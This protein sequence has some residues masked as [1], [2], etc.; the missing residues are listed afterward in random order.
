MK[1][2]NYLTL[3]SA[4]ALV[5]ATAGLSPA[6]IGQTNTETADA[7]LL[8]PTVDFAAIR[9]NQLR[10]GMTVAEVTSIMGDATKTVDYVNHAGVPMQTLEFS[11]GPIRSTITVA[12]GK[13]SGLALDVFKVKRDDLPAFTRP[14]WPGLHSGAV[15]GLLGNPRETRHHTYFGIK[16]DQL[17]FRRPGE[18]EISTFFVENHLVA[19]GLGQGVPSD[20][21]RVVL[22]SPS[23]TAAEDSDE[24]SIGI[25]NTASSIKALYGAARLD[26]EYRLNGQPAEHAIY[27]MQPGGSFVDVTFVDGVVTEFTD[28]GR[29]PD[30]PIFQGR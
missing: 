19:K 26:V 11:T 18:P 12:N 4:A 23:D 9:E 7:M 28:I 27:E 16:L 1:M 17:I 15:V 29:L 6:A 24:R 21:F 30:D 14:A 20:I 10:L 25:G 8:R 2:S 5:V 22:P 13:L 3:I